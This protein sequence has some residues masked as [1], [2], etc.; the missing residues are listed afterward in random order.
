MDTK[1]ANDDCTY[2]IKKKKKIITLDS[3]RTDI[4][5]SKTYGRAE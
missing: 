4:V 1:V 3:I 5:D 2:S